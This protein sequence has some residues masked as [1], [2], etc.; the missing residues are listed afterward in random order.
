MKTG[1]SRINLE[2]FQKEA[3]YKGIGEV[4]HKH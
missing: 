2:T 1:N 3:V 4:V